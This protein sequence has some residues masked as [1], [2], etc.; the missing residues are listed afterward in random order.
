ETSQPMKFGCKVMGPVPVVRGLG[1]QPRATVQVQSSTAGRGQAMPRSAF[2][3][4]GDQDPLG[5]LPATI[6]HLSEHTG[7]PARA[8]FAGLAGMTK[9]KCLRDAAARPCLRQSM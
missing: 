9:L 3:S 7:S 4:G 6:L 2:P 5:L 1:K 8:R